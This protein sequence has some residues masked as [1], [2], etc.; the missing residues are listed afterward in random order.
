M[1]SSFIISHAIILCMIKI[2]LSGCCIYQKQRTLTESSSESSSGSDD[3][4]NPY[5]RMKKKKKKP[6]SHSHDGT[7]HFI[8]ILALAKKQK[9]IFSKIYIPSKSS[10]SLVLTQPC[11]SFIYQG[12]ISSV[13]T[14]S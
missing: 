12:M 14:G 2:L 6:H 7:I 9:S 4:A 5:E 3:D 8:V 11:T 13:S 1:S 10:L